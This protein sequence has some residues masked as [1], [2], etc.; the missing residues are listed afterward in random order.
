M[1]GKVDMENNPQKGNE[2]ETGVRMKKNK[3]RQSG[4][5]TIYLLIALMIVTAVFTGSILGWLIWY[6]IS[7]GVSKPRET[8]AVETEE[9]MGETEPEEETEPLPDVSAINDGSQRKQYYYA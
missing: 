5:R 4:V 7:G 6:G 2:W 8:E 1:W 3:R 9:N